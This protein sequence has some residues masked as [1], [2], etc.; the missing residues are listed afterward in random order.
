MFETMVLAVLMCQPCHGYELK[1]H[2]A[3]FNPNNNK[4]YPTL[5]Q[6][7]EKGFVDVTVQI[8]DTRPNRHIYTITA[9]GR[10]RFRQLLMDFDVVRAQN[11]NEFNLRITFSYLLERDCLCKIL[12]L[13]EQALLQQPAVANLVSPDANTQ[14]I[15][16][17]Q[18][19]HTQMRQQQLDFIHEL[20]MKYSNSLP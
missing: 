6:L 13:R 9:S 16:R 15:T 11:I 14:D 1:H 8:Q 7:K 2:L 4:I 19:L 20:Q 12:A 17:L 3:N 18:A 5:R 10:E